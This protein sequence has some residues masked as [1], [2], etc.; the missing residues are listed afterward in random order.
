MS[1][2]IS[3]LSI[4]FYWSIYLSLC[5]YHTILMTVKSESEITQS[6]PALCD[7]MDCSLPGSSIHG[8][9]QARVLKWVAIS[10]SRWFSRSRDQTQVSRIVGRC[11]TIWATREVLFMTVALYYSLKSGRLIPPIP[12]FFIKIALAIWGF[13]VFPY[14]LW[15]F[16][17]SNLKFVP[18]LW[19]ILLVAW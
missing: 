2:L 19:N 12:F 15:I 3:G 14:K 17:C 11:F 4:L 6:C 5:Q 18:I 13:F 7:P 9:F 1:G 16:F 10:F 8:I